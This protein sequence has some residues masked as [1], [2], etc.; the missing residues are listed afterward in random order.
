MVS[1]KNKKLP[2]NL[3]VEPLSSL[4]WQCIG[5][6]SPISRGI[7]WYWYS[8][9]IPI[10]VGEILSKDLVYLGLSENGVY[11]QNGYFTFSGIW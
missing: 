10:S 1:L 4:K 5:G 11:S 2:Q 7:Q 6:E 8:F 9:A 3:V